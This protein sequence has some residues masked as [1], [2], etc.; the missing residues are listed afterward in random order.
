MAEEEE[1]TYTLIVVSETEGTKTLKS[2][3][4]FTGKGTATYPNQEIY[5]GD[6]VGGVI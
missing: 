3:H 1:T 2:S 6:Y 5:E 4:G